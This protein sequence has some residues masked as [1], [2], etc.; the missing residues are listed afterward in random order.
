MSAVEQAGPASL[1]NHPQLQAIFKAAE[2]R[3]LTDQELEEYRH[4][5]PD[6]AVRVEA[7]KEV[8][9]IEEEV[10][11]TVVED[12]FAVYPFPKH[13]R[14][15][16]VKAPRD[17]RY[18]SAYMTEAMLMNDPQWLNNKL[19][20]W[21]KTILQ[22][23]EFPDREGAAKKVLFASP[24]S[25]PGALEKLKPGQRSIHA[26]YHKLKQ[27]YQERLSPASFALM[28]P[29]LQQAIDVLAHD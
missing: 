4:V 25:D 19:L 16:S 24:S 27:Y 2:S 22:S 12:I 23:F 1:R 5:V 9:E 3:H 10:V 14:A 6:N 21:L 15:A 17:I 13:H 26:T 11:N 28:E 8:R 18:V 29:Y 20:I 7:A